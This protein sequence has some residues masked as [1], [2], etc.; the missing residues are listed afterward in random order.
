[1]DAELFSVCDLLLWLRCLPDEDSVA[2]ISGSED[3]SGGGDEYVSRFCSELM[4]LR[5]WDESDVL[6][7]LLGVRLG[8]LLAGGLADLVVCEVS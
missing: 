1:M 2:E 6:W 5:V 7:S 4:R 8:C 3:L